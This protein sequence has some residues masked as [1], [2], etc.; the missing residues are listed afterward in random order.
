MSA[1]KLRFRPSSSPYGLFAARR[2]ADDRQADRSRGAGRAAGAGR[3]RHQQSLRRARIFGEGRQGRHAADRRHADCASI[4]AT[5]ETT[6]PA[7][8]DETPGQYRAP[9]QDRDR[10]SQ[11]HARRLA[12]L[13]RHGGRR[14]AA[15]D[16]RRARRGR[17]RAD[18][19]DRRPRRP[20]RPHVRRRPAG[21]SAG[22]ARDARKACSATG[23]ISKSSATAAQRA[24]VEPQLLDLAYR[25]GVP[26]V[27]T[28][29]PYFAARG[30]FEAHDALLC[31]AEGTVTSVAERRRVTPEHYFKT[32]SRNARALRRSRGGDGQHGRDRPPRELPARRRAS[33]SCRAICATRRTTGR[34]PRWRREELRRQATEGLEARLAAHGPAEGQTREDYATRL[35]FEL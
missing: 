17:R 30:D 32:R 18:R 28:N 15:C 11:S 16:A 12:R 21:A 22:A 4:S 7:G 5:R 14:R 10:L 19:A 2:G 26:L 29:E 8:R 20:A 1:A 33:R 25:R 27:A 24:E 13:A 23:S 34:S 9:R 35:D 6:G 31:I 3:H